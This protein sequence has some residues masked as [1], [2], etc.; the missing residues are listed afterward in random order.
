MD[1]DKKLCD[2]CHWFDPERQLCWES[3][4]Y[5][6]AKAYYCSEYDPI[7]VDQ[8]RIIIAKIIDGTYHVIVGARGDAS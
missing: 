3:G 1:R 8:E 2:I 5:M 4:R 7:L 6:I